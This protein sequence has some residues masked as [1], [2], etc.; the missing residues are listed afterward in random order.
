MRIFIILSI[1]L[2][3]LCLSTQ[4][5][6]GCNCSEIKPD[7]NTSKFTYKRWLENFNG[8]VFQGRVIK[9]EEVESSFELV[10]TFE[11]NQYWKGVTG[12][13]IIIH[14]PLNAGACGA[15]FRKG[16]EF[17]VVANLNKNHFITDLCSYFGY[18]KY[19]ANYLKGLGKGITPVKK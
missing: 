15:P 10:V 5:V 19:K 2:F 3:L 17:F 4:R 6:F 11:V 16:E 1:S 13:E 14:T 18:T 9:T 7:K 8:A 12:Q